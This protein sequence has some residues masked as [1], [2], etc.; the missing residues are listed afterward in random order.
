MSEKEASS[1]RDTLFVWDGILNSEDATKLKWEG[2]WVGVEEK[3][4]SDAKAPKR[5]AFDELVASDMHFC[6][7]GSA[8]EVTTSSTTSGKEEEDEV[9]Y[10]KACLADGPGWDLKNDGDE[11]KKKH[12]DE[13]HDIYLEN[14]KWTGNLSNPTCNLIFASGKNEYGS[15]ISAGWMR[16]GNRLTLARRNVGEDERSG[17]SLEDVRKNILEQ[18][19]VDEKARIPPW[20]CSVMNS[21]YNSKKRAGGDEDEGDAKKAKQ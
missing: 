17:W 3:Q 16:P 4:A 21:E 20:Q 5:G 15:F 14:L 2:T 12:S 9:T 6:V 10:F 8:K 18:V 7:E 13:T 19:I 11:E 1:W